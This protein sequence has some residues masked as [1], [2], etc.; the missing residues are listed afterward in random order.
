MYNTVRAIVRQDKRIEFLDPVNVPAGT[1]VLVTILPA[2]DREF[3]SK[4]GDQTLDKIW[5]ND[6]DDVYGALLKR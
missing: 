3:W 2:D 4:A 6:E 1:E 5:K